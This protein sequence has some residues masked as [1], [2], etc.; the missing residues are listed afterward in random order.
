LGELGLQPS[1][2][3]WFQ[4]TALHVYM[5]HTRLRCY[6]AQTT[7]IYQQML[8]DAFFEDIEM[9]IYFEYNIKSQRFIQKQM[10]Q[11]YENFRGL[12][13]AYDEGILVNDAVL[14]AAFW[15]NLF[16]ST[17]NTVDFEKL[18]KIVNYFGKN[19]KLLDMSG[20]EAFQTGEF[21]FLSPDR[22]PPGMEWQP[23]FE[24]LAELI[25]NINIREQQWVEDRKAN[26]E[27]IGW[28]YSKP[29][30]AYEGE[31]PTVE[32]KAWDK[33]R[34]MLGYMDFP[35]IPP[36]QNAAEVLA[37]EFGESSSGSPNQ[38]SSAKETNKR[39]ATGV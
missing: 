19:M 35:A 33:E 4:V 16:Q 6:P 3:T 17:P 20:Q 37:E 13:V 36:P 24:D 18:A 11:L 22:T 8:V 34:R 9:R 30:K 14:A 15:R 10:K 25:M 38:T 32:D 39:S 31:L 7:R 1:F 12:T 27:A 2:A 21:G 26:M 23:H 28:D 5:L 29:V